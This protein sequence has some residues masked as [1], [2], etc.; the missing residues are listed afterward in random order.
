M[1]DQTAPTDPAEVT[2]HLDARLDDDARAWFAES[3]DRIGDDPAAV[4]VL[5]PAVSRRVGRGPLAPGGDGDDPF[6]WHR[7]DA[8]RA[9]LLAAVDPGAR[10]GELRDCYTHGDARERRGVLRSLEVVEVDDEVTAELVD[11][12]LRT[13]DVRLVAA[14]L[15]PAGVAVLDDDGFAQAVL[16]AVFVDLDLERIAGIPDRVTPE[17]SRMMADFVHERVAAGRAVP[18]SVWTVID[19]HPPADRLAAIEAERDHEDPHRAAA[20]AA[21]LDARP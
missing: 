20:A 6:V 14:A 12:A 4:R 7:D 5:F 3:R 2:A 18:A 1:T 19:R 17:L 8:G 16:K 11:D 21:A 10:P 9:L 15:G 13:N